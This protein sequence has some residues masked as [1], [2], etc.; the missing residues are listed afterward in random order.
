MSKP[1][2]ARVARRK[3]SS[4]GRSLRSTAGPGRSGFSE[5]PG[6]LPGQFK[7]RIDENLS[8]GLARLARSR[9][10]HAVH[11]N[12]P[13]A[14]RHRHR[15]PR[16]A[17]CAIGRGGLVRRLP[18]RPKPGPGAVAQLGE[19]LNGIQEV[20]GS[21]PLGSTN[22]ISPLGQDLVDPYD[23]A[24]VL[25]TPCRQSRSLLQVTSRVP[26]G[27]AK[28]APTELRTTR[29]RIALLREPHP[30]PTVP[31]LVD[32]HHAGLLQGSSPLVD[33]GLPRIA[34]PVSQSS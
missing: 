2:R 8:P 24:L 31:V 10:F 27:K 11:V 5:E 33:R 18:G 26:A 22:E 29:P 12:F 3:R 21:I 20:S 6:L 23:S 16:H 1:T 15:S 4:L 9:G 7:L 32:E 19:R 30:R 25:G 28:L 34:P 17:S 13:T 14:P